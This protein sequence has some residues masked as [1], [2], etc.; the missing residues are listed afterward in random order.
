MAKRDALPSDMNTEPSPKRSKTT[1][2]CATKVHL[3]PLYF[4]SAASCYDTKRPDGGWMKTDVILNAKYCAATI[5]YFIK[6]LIR[7][8]FRRANR[9]KRPFLLNNDIILARY[10]KADLANIFDFQKMQYC[11]D[12]YKTCV[13]SHKYL[14][15]QFVRENVS[16]ESCCTSIKM[17]QVIYFC[18]LLES[19]IRDC[20]TCDWSYITPASNST[21]FSRIEIKK[22]SAF[23]YEQLHP[24]TI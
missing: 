15:M 23:V 22:L 5:E 14:I 21:P 10:V 17:S 16:R 20:A 24:Q 9:L 18:A 3:T 2:E 19:L 8:S 6:E 13:F 1:D 7:D 11:L 12:N 4:I